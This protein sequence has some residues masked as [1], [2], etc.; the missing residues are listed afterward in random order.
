MARRK[1]PHVADEVLD[2][3]LSGT[4]AA[5]ALQQGGLLDELKKAL[6][7]RALNAE[8]EHHLGG[9]SGVGN[10]RNGYGRKTV[11]TDTGGGGA[12][13]GA[14]GPAGGLRP[15]THV[16]QPRGLPPPA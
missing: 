14:R 9:E 3:L 1:L 13:G 12:P 7:E 11:L 2:Q 4:D 15:A 16:Q 6:A 5:A 8:M 10:S